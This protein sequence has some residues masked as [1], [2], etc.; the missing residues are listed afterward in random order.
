MSVTSKRVWG[1]GTNND[2]GKTE[3]DL[4]R[5][6]LVAM[7][8][9]ASQCPHGLAEGRILNSVAKNRRLTATATTWPSRVL[10]KPTIQYRFHKI[11]PV[12]HL[13]SLDVAKSMSGQLR[14]AADSL[15][16][17]RIECIFRGCQARNVIIRKNKNSQIQFR[18]FNCNN[19][20][21]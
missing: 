10:C 7:P 1:I 14:R 9:P 21:D 5:Q 11:P 13:L 4:L 12:V 2:T 19:F 15:Q 18:P 16:L 17:P 20:S 8:L 6:N 3:V